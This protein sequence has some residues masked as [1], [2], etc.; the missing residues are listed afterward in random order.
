MPCVCRPVEGMSNP[1]PV[2]LEDVIFHR[3]L[4]HSLPQFFVAD[5][6]WLMNLEDPS[7]ASVNENLDSLHGSGGGSL[8]LHSIQQDRIHNVV[9]E[10][11]ILVLMPVSEDRQ[12]F[13]SWRKAAL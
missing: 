13:F 8:G 1:P 9:L 12:T 10:T 5:L 4:F 7:E 6:V 2:Y 3:L 11:L